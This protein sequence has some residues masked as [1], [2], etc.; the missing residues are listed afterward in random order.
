MRVYKFLCEKYGL[1]A[2]RERR[3][4]IS[5]MAD[6]NDP[7][8]LLPLQQSNR[9]VRE[10]LHAVKLRASLWGLLCFSASWHDPVI[11]AHYSDK[12]RGLCLGFDIPEDRYQ[13]IKY[14]SSPLAFPRFRYV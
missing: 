14:V 11:W 13:K 7:F 6:L 4:K 8:E 12:H 10:A 9:R 3:I 5:R 2:L 1:L